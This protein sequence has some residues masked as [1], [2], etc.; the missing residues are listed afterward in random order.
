[1]NLLAISLA[2]PPLAYPRSVQVARLLANIPA[3]STLFCADE[4]G[5]RLDDTIEPE[6]EGRL[7][8]CIRIPVPKGVIDTMIDRFAYRFAR[9]T[10]NKRNTT[11]DPYRKWHRRVV[12]KVCETYKEDLAK[13]DVLVTF[14]QPFTD[15]LIGLELKRRV[16]LPWLAHFSDPWVDN[17]FTPFDEESRLINLSL[18]R[19]VAEAADLLVFTS[20]ETV[21]LFFKKYPASL[22]TKS[23]ILPQCYAP[24]EVERYANAAGHLTIRYLGNFY[25]SRTPAPLIAGIRRMLTEVPS[26]L[27]EV[28]IE[29]IGPG[30]A[31]TLEQLTR[32]LP[33]GLISAHPSVSYL[34][35][36]QLM[37]GA[38]GLIVID[39]PA[40]Q[41]VFLPSKLID[42]IGADR[43]IFGVTP[44][45]TAAT[46]IRSLGG[47]VADPADPA[48]VAANL[49][50]FIGCLRKRREY[51][52][53][54]KWG[55]DEVRNVYSTEAVTARF[56][57]MLHELAPETGAGQ[58]ARIMS[59]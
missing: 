6:A 15:H 37:A 34:E 48:E 11:P 17:P 9:S 19:E 59:G 53:C 31:A 39:A 5:A 30:D 10:W 33:P 41:S 28:K 24:D 12:A 25:G 54:Q 57:E 20:R 50:E 40:D 32:G 45:G 56:M 43:P 18:E 23:R 22:K 1:M 4:P 42:Y 16:G 2:F 52:V 21:D 49:Q 27:E 29:L 7:E 46:L 36:R 8:A 13:P 44:P 38:D 14:A 55:E 3:R 35:S 51:P 26:A 47:P 58:R